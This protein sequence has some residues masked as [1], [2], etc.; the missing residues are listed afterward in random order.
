M[1]FDTSLFSLGG[2]K[3]QERLASSCPSLPSVHIFRGRHSHV[4]TMERATRVHGYFM[5]LWMV[6][7]L[8]VCSNQSHRTTRRSCHGHGQNQS[9]DRL[10]RPL[11]HR[12]LAGKLFNV[13]QGRQPF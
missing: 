8:H 12:C 5:G 11:F 10:W 7:G 2:A 4:D 3:R 1:V 6:F 13:S 9:R